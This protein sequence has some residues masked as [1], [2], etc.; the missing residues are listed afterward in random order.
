MAPPISIKLRCHSWKQLAALYKRDLRRS[1]VFLKSSAPPPLETPV[2]ISLTLP[3]QEV[4]MLNGVV[5]EHIPPGG[6]NGRGPGVDIQLMEIPSDAVGKIQAALDAGQPDADATPPPSAPTPA[7]DSPPGAAEPPADEGESAEAPAPRRG[8]T[9]PPIPPQARRAAGD[10]QGAAARP[11]TPPPIPPEARQRPAADVVSPPVETPAEIPAAPAEPTPAEPPIA[12]VEPTPAEPPAAAADS[13]AAA[14]IDLDPLPESAAPADEDV[15]D[16]LAGLAEEMAEPTPAEP[17]DLAAEPLP[18]AEAMPEPPAFTEIDPLAE[19]AAPAPEAAAPAPEAAA[20]DQ[21]A[22][23]EDVVARLEQERTSLRTLNPFQIL[24]VGYETTDEAVAEAYASLSARYQPD[25]FADASQDAR[26]VAADI[27]SLV[28]DAYRM[29]STAASRTLVRNQ[30]DDT[31]PAPAEEADAGAAAVEETDATGPAPSEAE[32]PAA[33]AAAAEPVSVDDD[34]DSI[35]EATENEIPTKPVMVDEVGMPIR[36][37]SA[38]DSTGVPV[39]PH[40]ELPTKP[41]PDEVDAV[42]ASS[43]STGAAPAPAAAEAAPAP[44]STPVA[45]AAPTP[46]PTPVAEAAPE[47]APEPEAAPTPVAEAT[48]EPAAAERPL[49]GLAGAPRFSE[50]IECLDAGKYKEATSLY[51]VARR[52]DPDDVGARAGVELSEGLRYLAERDRLEAAQRFEAVLELDPDN[53]R[54]KAELAEIRRQVAEERKAALV[55]LR[56]QQD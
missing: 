24:G 22:V 49:L 43:A 38:A 35:P 39:E 19:P 53:G 18:P 4:V 29:L 15:I 31:G 17:P 26:A 3:T 45:E 47:P 41:V 36:P 34:R 14:L 11:A 10:A 21:A 1:A 6:L 51:K 46:E 28:N 9:P 13:P 20:P 42:A 52:R 50:A 40:G 55:R 7:P 16:P 44:E 37:S 25:R 12:A 8:A 54:A 27:Y 23:G 30:L 5:H 48:P 56:E 2:R 33:E 32:V